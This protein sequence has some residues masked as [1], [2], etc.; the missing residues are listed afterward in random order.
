MKKN[1]LRLIGIGIMMS[2]YSCFPNKDGKLYP[3]PSSNPFFISSE[4]QS[5]E[6]K[7]KN[8]AD[9]EPYKSQWEDK[10]TNDFGGSWYST[11]IENEWI[12]I[13]YKNF[14]GTR[15]KIFVSV[16]ENLSG[17]HRYYYLRLIYKPQTTLFT[18]TQKP[19]E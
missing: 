10:I 3:K 15:D 1:I 17:M 4:E 13:Y 18:I 7:V 9:I 8:L 14:D 2:I 19:K 5:V 6:I 12:T 11:L 16:K